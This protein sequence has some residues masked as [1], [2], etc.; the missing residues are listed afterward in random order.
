M[1]VWGE[2]AQWRVPFYFHMPIKKDGVSEII[3]CRLHFA[4]EEMEVKRENL[5][6]RL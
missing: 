4:Y 2:G 6:N 1:S 5:L 3:S